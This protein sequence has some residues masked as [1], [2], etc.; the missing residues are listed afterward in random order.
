MICVRLKT[1]YRLQF[2]ENLL[3]DTRNVLIQ[4]LIHFGTKALILCTRQ[5]VLIFENYSKH[6]TK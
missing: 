4:I 2:A 1:G 5:N 6:C 3:N